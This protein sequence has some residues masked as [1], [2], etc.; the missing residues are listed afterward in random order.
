[1]IVSERVGKATLIDAAKAI[2]DEADGEVENEAEPNTPPAQLP[3][4]FGAIVNKKEFEALQ[5]AGVSFKDP[6]IFDEQSKGRSPLS[7]ELYDT[8]ATWL[9]DRKKATCEKVI[10]GSIKVTAIPLVEYYTLDPYKKIDG[11]HYTI[12]GD[13]AFAVP[14]FVGINNGFASAN[15]LAKVLAQQL[16]KY[17]LCHS[18]VHDPRFT[19]TIVGKTVSSVTGLYKMHQNSF[20]DY[21]N[22]VNALE[23]REGT[24]AHLKNFAVN[25][26]KFGTKTAQTLYKT[27]KAIERVASSVAR[28]IFRPL[29][30]SSSGPRPAPKTPPVPVVPAVPAESAPAVP[31]IAPATDPATTPIPATHAVP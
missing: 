22:Y 3:V 21:T 1:M 26:A 20:Q 6:L 28:A 16:M 7:P 25:L 8:I 5:G 12:V 29:L 23:T 9:K 31:G 17:K 19:N 15:V 30:S 18:K 13:A 11:V 14:Y 27:R 4:A 24:L 10:P 2:S